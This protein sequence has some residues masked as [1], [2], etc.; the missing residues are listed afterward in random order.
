MK[1]KSIEVGQVVYVATSNRFMIG[2]EKLYEY[3]VTKVNGTSFYA[4]GKDFKHDQKFSRKT[5][6]DDGGFGFVSK[7]YETK[8]QYYRI[9]ELRK[10]RERLKVSI[11]NSLGKLNISKL[12]EIDE[13][14]QQG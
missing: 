6:T 13:L 1:L 4:R 2:E 8:E 3:I 11:Q 12:R 10:E 5:W 9:V 14:I 7:A